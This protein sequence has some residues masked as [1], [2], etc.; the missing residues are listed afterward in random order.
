MSS[1]ISDAASYRVPGPGYTL[2]GNSDK[3]AA[4]HNGICYLI[5]YVY[6]KENTIETRNLDV[7]SDVM[8][9]G[10]AKHVKITQIVN[11]EFITDFSMTKS[12]INNCIAGGIHG[13]NDNI[14][15]FT[16]QNIE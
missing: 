5:T 7:F 14:G 15:I 12:Y 6:I 8:H 16:Q 13:A 2:G 4:F 3:Q 9:N 1:H 11:S 10:A